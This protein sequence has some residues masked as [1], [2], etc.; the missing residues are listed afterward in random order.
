MRRLRIALVIDWIGFQEVYSLPI[1][2]GIARSLG[3]HTEL[4][5]F[6]PSPRRAIKQIAAFKPDIVGYSVS[7]NESSRYLEINARLKAELEFFSLFGGPHPT[8]FPKYVENEGVDAICRG[9]ADVTLPV[10]LE[11]FGTDRMYETS[12]FAFQGDG[13]PARVNPLAD[14]VTDLDSVPMMD[15]ELLYSKSRFLAKTPIKGFFSGRGCPYSCSY[16]FNHAYKAMYQGKGTVVR[17]RGV[18][19]FLEEIKHVKQ[20]YPLGLI[21]IM[22][23][24]FGLDAEWLEEFAQRYPKEIGLPFT[25]QARPNILSEDY[26]RQLK[27]SGCH[28]V[29]MAVECSNEQLRRTVANR[30]IS[31]EQIRVGCEH[32]KGQGI[33]IGTYNMLGLPGEKEED[34]LRTVELNQIAGVDYAEASILQPYPGTRINEYCRKEGFLDESTE[35]FGGQYTSTVLNFEER[36]KQVIYVIHKMF[37]MMVDHPRLKALLPLLYKT[38]WLNR[39]LDFVYRLYYGVNMHR[40]LYGAKIPLALRLQQ[41]ARFFFAPSRS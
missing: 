40:R 16:C 32:L 6:G 34:L 7:S 20:R 33:R 38:P 28:A 35:S 24:T 25:C 17:R 12:N 9:E 5:E 30:H 37:P 31:N 26:C 23:D 18:S 13:E 19:S 22:D 3:H 2:S 10:F 41:S 15:R 4:F 27:R 14:L 21:R 29:L 8:F 1:I 39:A 36:F 11:H